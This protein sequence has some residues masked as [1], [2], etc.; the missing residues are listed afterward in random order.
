MLSFVVWNF[1]VDKV[2]R[3]PARESNPSMLS[4][5]KSLNDLTQRIWVADSLMDTVINGIT[6]RA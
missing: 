4:L 2:S 6:M 5:T 3:K 1:S